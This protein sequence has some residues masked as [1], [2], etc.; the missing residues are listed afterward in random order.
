M[1]QV[2]RRLEMKI[3]TNTIVFDD[4]VL[5]GQHLSIEAALHEAIALWEEVGGNVEMDLRDSLARGNFGRVQRIV[6]DA[7]LNLDTVAFCDI[8][9]ESKLY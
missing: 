9:E 7:F 4:Q 2:I 5:G 6:A 1:R 3:W 8:A